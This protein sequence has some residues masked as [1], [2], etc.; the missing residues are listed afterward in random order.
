[1]FVAAW[2]VAVGG[3]GLLLA[4]VLVPSEGSPAVLTTVEQKLVTQRGANG[5]VVIRRVPVTRTVRVVGDKEYVTE[6]LTYTPAGRT[7]VVTATAVRPVRVFRSQVVTRDGI[8]TTLQRTSTALQTV[9]N[10]STIS[11]TETQVRT[12][13][14]TR[15]ET[16]TRTETLTTPPETQ[17]VSRT[18]T[19]TVTTTVTEPAI[20]ITLP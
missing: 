18:E 16:V 10:R 1:L 2:V 5:K 14:A 7:E 20:T 12:E 4:W 19:E 11:Q 17:T 9:T 15:V 8:V 3:F 13:T 6:R